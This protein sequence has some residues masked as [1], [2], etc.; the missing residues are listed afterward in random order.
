LGDG[1]RWEKNLI[2]FG[3]GVAW[4]CSN[5]EQELR[6]HIY[7]GIDDTDTL[8]ADR[9]TGKLARWLEKALPDGCCMRGVVRQQLLVHEEVPYTSHNSAACV[10]VDAPDASFMQPVIEGALNHVETYALEGSDPGVCVA[11]EGNPALPRLT[12]FGRVCTHTVVAQG[13]A[14]KAASTFHLSGLGGTNDGIIGAAAAVGLTA[15]GWS[16]RFIEFGRLR[17]FPDVVRIADLEHSGI[18]VVSVDRNATVPGPEDLVHTNGWLRPR[19]WGR[20]PALLV[21]PNGNGTWQSIGEKRRRKH[22]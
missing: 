15:G 13:E 20:R 3:K 11:G 6:M 21:R 9:G 14:L 19:L 7:V 10:I 5:P 22:T 4:R 17:D 12:E 8:D 2:E 1:D 18:L 16:G